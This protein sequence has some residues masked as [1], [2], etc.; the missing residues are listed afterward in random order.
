MRK[1][2]LLLFIA[3]ASS[4][5]AFSQD[6]S[7]KG[8]DFYLCFPQHVPSGTL[9]KLSIW[10][11]SDKASSG[12]I[13]MAS[14][15][16][17]STFNIAA[18]GI[19]EIQVPFN[20]AHISNLESSNE[21]F[22]NIL[23]KSIRVKVDAGKPPVVAYVQQFGN[24]RSAA[25]LLLPVNVLGKKYYA[26]SFNQAGSDATLGGNTYRAR[27]QFQ[28][29]ATK[30]NTVVTITPMKNGVLGTPFTVT[31]PLAG[32]MIQYQPND[33]SAAT[34]DM[35][36]TF[37]ESVASGG[38]GCLPIAV[39][40]GSSNLTMGTKTPFCSGG[41]YD[42][43]FQQLYPV[44]TWG[45]N[46]GLVPFAN[47]PSGVPYRVMASEDNTNVY[48]DG[49]LVA[50]LNAGQIY[51]AAFTPNPSTV[52]A[53]TSITADKPICVAEYAQS[54]G[55]AGN[56]T[57][58]NQGDP[59]MVILNPIEQNISDITIFS[60]RQ[61]VINSQW[62]NVLMKTTAIPSFKISRNGG[63]LA[64]PTGTWAPFATLPG[65]SYLQEP[66]PFPGSGPNPLSDSYR[67][68][69]DSGF[70]A[71]AYGLGTNET[72]A[73]SAGT[74]IKD[75][76]QQLG[77]NTQYGIETSPSVCTGA[78]FQFKVCFPATLVIDSMDWNSSNTSVMSPNNFP[79]RVINPTID[80]TTS[81]GTSAIPVNWY[82]LPSFY[83]F[84]TPGIYTITI[85]N[86]TSGSDACGSEQDND[87]ELEVT[88]PPVASFTVIP[89]GCVAE[90]YQFKETTPQT[91]KATY[92]FWWDFGDPASGAANNASSQR[93]PTHIFSAPSAPGVPYKVRFSDITTPGCLS[94]TVEMFVTVPD[95]PKATIAG[96]ATT[97]INTLP[98][99]Q[100]TFT[101]TDGTA[102]Y[103]FDYNINGG[104]TI[105]T[106]KSV[107]GIVT[108][109]APTNVAGPFRY[110]LLA[111][112][113]AS[114]AGT[115]C[116]RTY[117]NTY[118][119]ITITPDATI[120]LRPLPDGPASQ[121]ICV[122]NPIVD[123]KY[124][125]GASG[126]G[127]AMD[128]N[129][130]LYNFPPGVSGSFAGGVY[131]ITGTPT[132]AGVYNYRIVS[133]GPCLTP[134]V[135]GTIT[136]N[137]D[138]TISLASGSGASTQTV[139]VNNL[140]APIVF[141][142]TGGGTN[143]T[144]NFSPA[145][146]G[147]SGTYNAASKK[148]TIIGAP[149]PVITVPTTYNYTVTATGLCLPGSTGGSITVNP[150]HTL[151][152]TSAVPTTTQTVCENVT[153][154]D[155]TYNVAGG[156]NNATVSFTPSAPA[157]ITG[158]YTAATNEF[159]ISGTPTGVTATTIY[160][161]TVTTTGNSCIVA[162]KTGAITVNSDAVISLSAGSG[163]ATQTVCVNNLIAPIAFDVTEG[164]TNATMI[165]TPP[166]PGV[167]GAYNAVSKKFTITGAPNPVITVPTTY[168]YTV[169]ATG[170][171]LPGSTG[172]SITV[173]PDHTLTLTSAVPT[174]IQTVCENVAIADITYNVAG[175]A[176]NATVTFIP[177]AP[178]GITGVYTAATNEFKI[179]GTPT[180]TTT[181]TTYN[182]TVTTTGNS[183]IIATKTGSITVNSDA[184]INLFS[185]VATQTVCVNNLI[186]PIVYDV[187]E[188]GTNATII[189]T[190][191][192]PG[193]S[194]A[195]NAAAKRF[196]ITGAPN[197]V[198]TV[199]TTYNYT[200][201]ATGLCLPSSVGGTGSI[202]V[203][204]DHTLT[205]T[206][207]GPTTNQTVCENVGITDI[208]Y[209]VAGGANNASVTFTP[210]APAGIT[211]VY[212]AA[213]NEFKISGTPTGITTTTIYN[214]TVT[215]TGNSCIVAAK[216]GSITVKADGD[217]S[218]TSGLTT[219]EVCRNV[220]IVPI[221]F[222]IAGGATGAT[223]SPALPA[224][225]TGSYSAGTYTIQGAATTAPVSQT[226]TITTTGSGCVENTATITLTI[227]Q[228]PTANFTYSSPNCQ[229]K[230]INFTD[231]STPNSGALNSWTWD[232]G[233]PASGV[234]NTSNLATP[235]HIFSA[236]G[237]YQVKL[238]VGTD[239]TCSS[240]PVIKSVTVNVN[241]KTG[242][243][244]PEACVNDVAV[245]TDTSKISVGTLDPAGYYWDFA[246][247][248]SG[249]AN[250]ST[251][252]NGSHQFSN[253][254]TYHVMHVSTSALGCKDTVYNDITVNA[255]NPTSAYMVLNAAALCSS[256]TVRIT[257]QSSVT[258]GA[259]TKIEIWW[260]NV[261]APAVFD[262]HLSPVLN[263]Q[264][265]HKYPTLQTTKTYD[266]RFRAYSGST[267]FTDVIKTITVNAT[268]KVQLNAFPDAC[269]DAAPYA[270]TQGSD[271]GGVA[272]SGVY[273]GPGITGTNTFNPALAGIGTHTIKYTYT[274]TAAGCLD[275]MSRNIV[276]RDT[277]TAN[278][279]YSKP[280]C[281]GDPVTF[282]DES[283]APA[284]I[285][286]TTVTWDFGDLSAPQTV[287]AGTTVSHVFPGANTYN[288]KLYNTS[289]YGCKS[290]VRTQSVKISP[291]PVPAFAFI[292]TSVCL[293]NAI[294]T[295]SNTSS[296]ADGTGLT[297]T[298]D[299]GDGTAT[300]SGVAAPHQF[301]GIGP[302][303]VTLTVR[304]VDGCTK[305]VS[306]V[307]NFIHPQ[308]HAVYTTNKA[309]VCIADDVVFTDVADPLDGTT[310]TWNW[311]LG[312]G[313]IRSTK[314]FTYT[315]STVDSF[316]VALYITNSHGCNSD[317]T[318]QLFAVYPYPAVNAGID[319]T[320]LEGG[321]VKLDP[322]VTGD[323]LSYLWTPNIYFSN[324]NRI[325]A[326]TASVVKEDITY[327]LTVTALGGCTASDKVFIQVLKFPGI[328]NTFSPN[329][330][331]IN[332]VW[333][334]QYL[335][336]Y[337]DNRVQVF[338]K[339]GQL[340]FE[341]HGYT[342]PWDGTIKG[343]P[344]PID[345]YY[346]VI[347]PGNGR[348]PITGYVTILK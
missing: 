346:Y 186:A 330:D 256:D 30:N 13:T 164:G 245:F 113:N 257:N 262:T 265:K 224:G 277:A 234:N 10:I 23:K 345:T 134:A 260:D 142:V 40:S 45:K 103:F 235:S 199:P 248:A 136:V 339:T 148:L 208:T 174:T 181:N 232:F 249:P 176:N 147:V 336:T 278:F 226:Y 68:V 322:T 225:I 93:N 9:A 206:S 140:I 116:E 57:G 80:S 89:G 303:T 180:G 58:G 74:Y 328:P 54:S 292:E 37:I 247:A 121:T 201:T 72:Y 39:F 83:S 96:A 152:L 241:P 107:G 179:S 227:D 333:A 12:T 53:A 205:L 48:F 335:N 338:T 71:I 323:D 230:F 279:S 318:N 304:S 19:A 95:L 233:D 190:P 238:T 196:T 141:D 16:F 197:P 195:Y 120:T 143:A 175:G 171:C 209:T 251:T 115:A 316:Y 274:A 191:P 160:N 4:F 79:L 213:T 288:V 342:K 11:T 3:L 126:T 183:C 163:P 231:A 102:E 27:S 239:K 109:N 216:T 284:G 133:Q 324:I 297:Y 291:Q 34:E 242:F 15:A 177:A 157:G 281:D 219:Q 162:T 85:T 42:P 28:I 73:Y 130:A 341:S 59:D 7:N 261:G 317:T 125:I 33:A 123:I 296:I 275:S 194:G 161:Y 295:F 312:D 243:M 306:H 153:I 290:T 229:S 340:V 38:G 200:V 101:G 344:L 14:G 84:S 35:T 135:T 236:A 334:I 88:N 266:I 282:K 90:P 301:T 313:S 319:R 184:A 145:L 52:K 222:A 271:I 94:D 70:N 128:P 76:S 26:I 155:I 283:T 214:Y 75:L 250:T 137:D 21:T 87:F 203:N 110:N 210:S 228:L 112:R 272:G 178:A 144:V 253:P 329:N 17:S 81:I 67:L 268:P 25:S 246:D 259:V 105:T 310:T 106:P 166:L 188:G 20:V 298:W 158:V 218:W 332:D 305:T 60:T 167:S 315:Y 280:V 337:P 31:F 223:I 192:L 285:N 124:D 18:N 139:C 50:T 189:F 169:T 138:A 56:G 187:T 36:G 5:I 321:S 62:V 252:M 114:P 244:V 104:A 97:C 294:V 276:V 100:V 309:S 264:Y 255:A 129:T 273:T 63:A 69:A 165:F 55:C 154:A 300:S 293:P 327:T 207:A 156:A 211:G 326:P 65:Y 270:L 24:A 46:F 308:P 127:A 122:N 92:H 215:T 331:G 22:T 149:N 240:T 82:S 119:D 8:K 307:V 47:Y 99:P 185:G 314:S 263:E 111:V 287:A 118:V 325:K 217:I 170:P 2:L 1:Y 202:T 204:P 6:F 78:P 49:L 168:N 267:C 343:K 61:E 98:Q 91:P 32:D 289:D 86:H 43:L 348:D 117:P 320:I 159:K 311:K 77:V 182:Y 198:I 64:L 302:Y 237:V 132:A 347:E 258:F 146:P 41:S 221:Q 172:G 212:T 220:N 286:I 193:V 269:Y 66:L 299:Y 151:T 254:G 29:I 51:P 108:V 173:N 150:D 131:T 44:S